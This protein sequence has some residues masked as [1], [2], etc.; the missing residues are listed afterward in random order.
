MSVESLTGD[1]FSRNPAIWS[2]DS[3]VQQLIGNR[4][5][6]LDGPAFAREYAA[7][8]TALAED[9]RVNEFSHIVLLAMGGSCLAPEVLSRVFGPQAG[10]PEMVALDSTS[11]KQIEDVERRVELNK[12]LFIVASKSGGTIETRSLYLYFFDR[13]AKTCTLPGEQF[14]AITDP[15]SE[16]QHTAEQQ[17]FRACYLNLPDIGGRYSAISY[18]GLLPAALAGI[19]IQPLVEQAEQALQDCASGTGRGVRIGQWLAENWQQGRDKLGLVLPRRLQPLGWWIEQ[20]IAESLGKDGKGILPW[21]TPGLPE[22]VADDF[23]LAVWGEEAPAQ[24]D[25][26]MS[27]DDLQDPAELAAEFV[28]WQVA[29]ALCGAAMELNPFDEP[30][31]TVAKQATSKILDAGIQPMDSV[32]PGVDELIEALPEDGYFCLLAYL[33]N[34]AEAGAALE[35]LAAHIRQQTARPV[36]VNWGPRYLHS[37]GQL[38]K[39]GPDQ[40]SFLVLSVAD[41]ADKLVPGADYDFQTLITAQAQGDFQVLRERGRR[42]AYR[43]I[44]LKQMDKLTEVLGL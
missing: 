14:V 13:V 3:Q 17:A 5:G 22:P 29:T 12:T 31:V 27:M 34:T 35:K 43:Q 38:H 11:P 8:M 28:H 9:I 37:S 41:G 16:L 42:V 6:W 23:C 10:W 32:G 26:V 36:V 19:D 30:D 25:A 4:L 2:E 44:A 7:S 24:N 33:P 20:L 18:F 40:G 1:L 15:G 21:L 39:G